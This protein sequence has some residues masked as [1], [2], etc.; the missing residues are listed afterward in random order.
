MIEVLERMR[1]NGLYREARVEPPGVDFSSN[2]Y[3]GL[4]HSPEIR[5]RL[6]GA[7]ESGC[8]LGATGSRLL[9][10]TT[11]I[12]ERVEKGIARRFSTEA[13][14]LFSSG[15]LANLAVMGA[16][17]AGGAEFFS[18]ALNHASLIDGMRLTSAKKSIFKHNDLDHL[19]TL[20]ATSRA[21]TKV[22]VVESVYGMDGDLAPLE[23]LANA[24]SK[25]GA[26]LVVD[27]AH[28]T[29]VFGPRGLGRLSE[30]RHDPERTIG[31]HTGGKA[32]GA[33]GAFVTSSRLV[34]ELIVNVARSFIF[35]TALQPLT[36]LQIEFA[37]ELLESSGGE[38]CL[39]LAERLSQKLGTPRPSSHILPIVLG[40]N[41]RAI[42]TREQLM[43]EGFRVRAI[44]SPTVPRGTERLRIACKSYHTENDI[45]AL[46]KALVRRGVGSC[47]FS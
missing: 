47:D 45:D 31:I 30:T 28:A 40:S 12:H 8:P 9:S 24:A 23:G 34:A 2:D 18:D 42:A 27:E 43:R 39:R 21:P 11:E 5:R 19:E 41:E 26:W 25:C 15:Y 20:L 32:L 14:L 4:S 3:L 13:S 29:G 33:Q 36:A 17:G 37:L 22:I 44:R 7:L 35:T 38:Q 46:A 16:L 1:E 10:G 6:I